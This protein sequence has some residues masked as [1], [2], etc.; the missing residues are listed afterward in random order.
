MYICPT[1]TYVLALVRF[2]TVSCDKL[3]LVMSKSVFTVVMVAGI[4]NSVDGSVF[5]TCH[6][7]AGGGGKYRLVSRLGL[8]I[9]NR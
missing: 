3:I 5:L 7:S 4:C 1:L 2:V 6:R 9:R 8:L